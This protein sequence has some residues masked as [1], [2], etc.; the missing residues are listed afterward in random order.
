[1]KQF[2]L[3]IS[4]RFHNYKALDYKLFEFIK[5]VFLKS[6]LYN[7]P[8]SQFKRTIK[9]PFINFDINLLKVYVISL[10]DRLDRRKEINYGLTRNNI[11]FSFINGIQLKS[12]RSKIHPKYFTELSRKHLTEGSIGCILSHY[13][14]MKAFLKS[15]YKYCLILEDD[16][17]V[18]YG[19]KTKMISVMKLLPLDFDICYLGGKTPYDYG[20]WVSGSIFKPIFPRKGAY[21]YLVSE[22]GAKKIISQIFPIGITRGGIDTILGR[23]V[24]KSILKAYQCYPEICAVNL[25]SPSNIYNPS[26]PR[27]KIS[28]KHE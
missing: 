3:N 19:F 13:K 24:S 14:T 18:S 1:M 25:N 28:L 9:S 26:T 17:I 15:S 7:F 20:L 5:L 21:S 23:L 11:A 22:Q 6:V 12:G 8:I 16:A 4:G 2:I 27:K 10:E